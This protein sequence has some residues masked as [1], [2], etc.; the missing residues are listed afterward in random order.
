ML[1]MGYYFLTLAKS[2]LIVHCI[3]DVVMIY[4]PICDVYNRERFIAVE[5]HNILKCWFVIWL[6]CVESHVISNVRKR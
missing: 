2:T 6:N 3:Y 5:Y 1:F 4:G